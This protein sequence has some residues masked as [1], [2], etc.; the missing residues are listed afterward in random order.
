MQPQDPVTTP[1]P[2]PVVPTSPVQP[3][4]SA[5]AGPN[6]VDAV[7]RPNPPATVV[8]PLTVQVSAPDVAPGVVTPPVPVIAPA[9]PVHPSAP[10]SATVTTILPES[11]APQ[12]S[13]NTV[14]TATESTP[15]PAVA[16]MPVA[17]PVVA[18]MPVIVPSV[19][20]VLEGMPTAP[21]TPV[22]SVAG[23]PTAITETESTKNYMVAII[24][25]FFFS[26]LGV[27]RFYLGYVGIGLA[28]LLTLGGLGIW[29]LI[30]FFLIVFG[31]V[32]DRQG[33]PLAGR[34]ANKKFG[35]AFAVVYVLILLYSIVSI[36]ARLAAVKSAA[37]TNS[38][39]TVSTGTAAPSNAADTTRRSNLRS[40]Q[41]HIESYGYD[42]HKYPTLSNMN[43]ATF[44]KTK[45]VGIDP[46]VFSDPQGTTSQL[47]STPAAKV[48]SY[49]TTP[50]GCNNIKITCT[51]YTLTAILSTGTKTIQQSLGL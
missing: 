25:S 19:T 18:P 31:K 6:L 1:Q 24:L 14:P 41:S 22:I 12:A 45:L 28:K 36:P 46:Y 35:Y 4:V 48:I 5:S 43:D 40:L 27:D 49:E 11:L 7:Q 51:G 38:V 8:P 39:S 13:S 17:A 9:A 33:L 15:G 16:N 26:S 50:V 21:M 30:D 2:Q 44:R 3:L 37:K 42:V 32:H 29:A 23:I 20:P 34:A 47:T 10:I